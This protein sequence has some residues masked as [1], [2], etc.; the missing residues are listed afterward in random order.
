MGKLIYLLNVSLDGFIETPD[1]GLEWTIVD[2]ELHTWFNDQTRTLDASLY[3]RRLYELMAAYWPTAEEDPSVTDVER[4]FARIWKA[5]PKI[6]FS[7]SL[8][9]VE[10]N[11][12]LVR[13]DVGTVLESVRREFDGDLD[14]GGP[15][16][17]GQF[18]RR[19]LVDEYRLLIHP[20]VLGTG[21]PFWPELD[22]PLRLRL[23]ETRSFASGAELRSYVPA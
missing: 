5:M 21:T 19:G 10:H 1:H 16:L 2:D 20:V 6:V 18:V 23:V 7:T 12:R 13:G 14:V 17:A 22:A 3:G 9:H 8:E 11:S 15:N 4:E